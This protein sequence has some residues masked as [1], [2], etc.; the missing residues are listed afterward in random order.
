MFRREREERHP[1]RLGDRDTAEAAD[2]QAGKREHR[3]QVRADRDKMALGT[4][5]VARCDQDQRVSTV[6]GTS[7]RQLIL[8]E[9]SVGPASRIG[10]FARRDSSQGPT[11]YR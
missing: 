1:R 5:S 9:L 2:L 10:G 6:Q 4:R 3:L 8:P 11:Q 7:F